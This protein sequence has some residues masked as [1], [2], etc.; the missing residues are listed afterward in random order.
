MN[1]FEQN[2]IS[3]KAFK[4]CL[5]IGQ[6]MRLVAAG[7]YDGEGNNL[8]P[9]NNHKGLNL[10]R[11]VHRKQT[12]QIVFMMLEGEK[13]GICSWLDWPKATE[14]TFLRDERGFYGFTITDRRPFGVQLSYHFETENP[15][16]NTPD[17]V[18]HY[19]AP[20]QCGEKERA[21][22]TRRANLK[23]NA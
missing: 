18:L 4:E 12:N 5:A 15:L 23:N 9:D 20:M 6:K 16:E 2:P 22:L 7:C 19:I 21:E 14:L 1:I 3:L 8:R 13:K 11:E 10:L 17:E